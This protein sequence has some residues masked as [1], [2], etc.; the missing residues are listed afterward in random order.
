MAKLCKTC[1]EKD[2]DTTV[3]GSCQA[4]SH[5]RATQL[6]NGHNPWTDSPN[7]TLCD[8]CAEHFQFCAW[9]WG[10]LHGHSPVTVPTDKT[11]VRANA[12]DNGKT[13][14]GMY[15]GEQVLVEM[16]VDRFS[17]KTWD[18]KSTSSGVRL[19]A[20]RM[21][22]EGG[23]WAQ[24]GK[25]EMYFDLSRSDPKAFIEL[26]EVAEHQW[27]NVTNP[28]TWKVIVEVKH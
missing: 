19:A 12:Q 8:A 23:Q 1:Q 18:V 16:T 13:I 7:F 27:V 21:I 17:G 6:P 24:Y 2:P 11:F 5:V 14:P 3:R 26:E 4:S 22:T 9:C 10:P 25:H 15:V 20:Y 28:Q